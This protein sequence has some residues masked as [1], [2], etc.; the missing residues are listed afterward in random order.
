MKRFLT[1]NWLLRFFILL[2]VVIIAVW[3]HVLLKNPKFMPLQHIKI[4]ATYQ[5]TKPTTI[6]R[7][8][9]PYVENQGLF[10][11]DVA[12]LKQALLAE[13]WIY[14]IDVKR[15]WPNTLEIVV[16]EQQPVA[17]WNNHDLLNANADVFT[18]KPS[19]IPLNL[20]LFRGPDEQQQL[21]LQL[22]QQIN[23]TVAPLGLSITELDLNQ[24]HAWRMIMSDGTVI[25]LG[26]NDVLK[27]LQNF[28]AAYPKIFS[29]P[30]R[31]PK[32]VDLRY[33]NGLAVQ[34]GE[35]Q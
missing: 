8:T 7:I 22:W 10:S 11:V 9:A 35:T 23:T 33:E 16:I 18:P 27:R 6:A 29:P 3:I 5:H 30:V 31:I 17:R 26:K 24:R 12:A 4:D 21:V 2:I 32:S 34:W 1:F 25:I 20:P 28:V 15:I 14:K 19:A 13:P